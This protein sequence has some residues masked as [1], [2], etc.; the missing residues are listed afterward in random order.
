[1][2]FACGC[3]EYPSFFKETA[4]RARKEHKCCECGH[5]ITPGQE[6]Q[7]IFMVYEGDPDTYKVC[8][9]C[10]DLMSAFHDLGYCTAYGGFFEDYGDWLEYE[11]PFPGDDEDPPTGNEMASAIQLKHRDWQPPQ[12]SVERN[13]DG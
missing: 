10:A 8:E 3:D 7:H 2:G 9:R 12:P 5:T 11:R 13:T 6:Y 1:M 4:R